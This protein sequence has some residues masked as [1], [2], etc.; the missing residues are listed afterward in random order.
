MN[1]QKCYLIC[2]YALQQYSVCKVHIPYK[3][4]IRRHMTMSLI[5]IHITSI[6]WFHFQ[7]YKVLHKNTH[8]IDLDIESEIK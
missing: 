5:N 3:G 2:K 6:D 4:M 8:T 1:L 7:Y